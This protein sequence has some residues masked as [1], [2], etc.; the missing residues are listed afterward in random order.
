MS[1]NFDTLSAYVDGELD[2]ETQK[3]VQAALADDPNLHRQ[4]SDLRDLK[5]DVAAMRGDWAQEDLAVRRRSVLPFGAAIAA[6]LI[7]I[8]VSAT[9]AAAWLGVARA[10]GTGL[11]SQM[12]AVHDGFAESGLN[13]PFLPASA[14]ETELFRRAGLQLIVDEVRVM[15]GSIDIRH[16][17]YAGPNGC[18]VSVFTI[19]FEAR[20]A[21]PFVSEEAGL[22]SAHWDIADGVS[23]VVARAMDP[24]RFAAIADA[25]ESIT[26]PD[27]AP[28]VAGVE[29]PRTSCVG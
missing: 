6:A 10:P 27:F 2:T 18:R 26:K 12:V 19:P 20:E 29:F 14:P 25:L 7:V 4:V 24:E 9:L 5:R 1:I 22:L 3:F 15:P 8:V 17:G 21:V 11:A 23:V 13:G 28:L 16:H